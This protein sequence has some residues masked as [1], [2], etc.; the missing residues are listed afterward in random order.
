MPIAAPRG[1]PP[2]PRGRAGRLLSRGALLVGVLAV[3][4]FLALVGATNAV[5][6]SDWL[7]GELNSDPE[8][9]LVTHTGARS[10]FPGHLRFDTLVLRSRDSNVEWEARL[11]GVSVRVRLSDLARRRFRADSVRAEGLSFHLRELLDRADATPA[12]L[13]RFPP[14]AGFTGPPLL[15]PPAPPGPPGDPWSIDIRD[16]RVEFVREVWIDSWRWRGEGRLTGGFFLRPGK[17]AEVFPGELSALA[18]VLSWGGETV[19]REAVGSVH[20]AVPRFIT[21]KYRGNEVW[22]IVSGT[23]SLGGTL[24]SLPFLSPS[25]GAPR[26]A[27]GGEGTVRVR[28]GLRTG[29]GSGRIDAEAGGLAARIGGKAVRGAA[30]VSVVASRID[31]PGG[32]IDFDGTRARLHDA[33]LEGAPGAPWGARVEAR[34]A[35]LG[36]AGGTLDAELF[37]HLADGRPLVVLVPSGAPKWIAGLL[38]LR[39]L[40]ASGRL[41]AAPGLLA[42]SPAR[43]EAGTFSLHADWR[44]A[45]GRSWGALLVRK[46]ALSAGLGLAGG[47]GSAGSGTSLHL[48]DAA[49]WYA[50]EAR[51]G[52]LRTDRPRAR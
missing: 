40:D 36:L 32:G 2:P 17:E 49:G 24:D 45:R 42:I 30:R 33:S 31:F 21:K 51:N 3:T 19:S 46:G 6:R 12:R 4:G 50:R 48:V 5:L 41:R 15:E 10:L 52:G 14:I 20:A 9:L 7:S 11:E 37:A 34:R 44:E 8:A 28:V 1:A 39:D 38:D 35:R 29:R 43:A 22:K 16:L 18:G 25:G 23:A 47:G 26:V 27:P 13:G